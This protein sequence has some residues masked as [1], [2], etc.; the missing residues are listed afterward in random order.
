MDYKVKVSYNTNYP[1]TSNQRW[2]VVVNDKQYLV[3]EIEMKDCKYT[4]QLEDDEKLNISCEANSVEFQIDYP[5][6]KNEAQIK[7]FIK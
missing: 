5:N 2:S 6:S 1:E 3:D 7:V 4:S